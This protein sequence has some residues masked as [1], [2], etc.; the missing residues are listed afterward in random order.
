MAKFISNVLLIRENVIIE[1]D[2]VSN[3]L[4]KYKTISV[5]SPPHMK[6]ELTMVAPLR[7]LASV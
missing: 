2:K 6:M 5:H 1:N 3:T 7:V 4:V